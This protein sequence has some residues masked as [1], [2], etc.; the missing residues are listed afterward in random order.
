MIENFLLEVN[1]TNLD[2]STIFTVLSVIVAIQGLIMAIVPLI[3]HARVEKL[4]KGYREFEKRYD[5][6][7][8]N[9]ENKLKAYERKFCTIEEQVSECISKVEREQEQIREIS[10]YLIY[11]LCNLD[12]SFMN[13]DTFLGTINQNKH[14][15]ILNNIGI[16]YL[17]RWRHVKGLGRPDP[18]WLNKST[19]CFEEALKKCEDSANQ[20]VSTDRDRA[21]ILSN[22]ADAYDDMAQECKDTIAEEYIKKA[23]ECCEHA[24]HLDA[25]CSQAH[26]MLA[27]IYINQADKQKAQDEAMRAI[28]LD[29]DNGYAYLTMAESFLSPTVGD[30]TES[31]IQEFYHHFQKAIERGCPVWTYTDV[32]R[33][34][35]IK[36]QPIWNNLWNQESIRK[37][38]FSNLA[39]RDEVSYIL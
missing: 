10:S 13:Q 5:L 37:A 3:E 31:D 19:Y 36:K 4:F 26:N 21:L 38:L 34:D 8:Q 14:Y 25:H 16:C 23:K 7:L 15:K 20:N 28:E 2:F 6:L 17:N 33:Y 27:S 9:S 1:G 30:M 32:P 18:I 29:D 12:Q 39:M 11:V 22:L 35:E 24:I